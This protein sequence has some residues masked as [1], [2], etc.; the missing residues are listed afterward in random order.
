MVLRKS[1]SMED[2]MPTLGMLPNLRDLMLE[3]AYNGKKK[4][5]ID[6][7]FRQLEFL[8]LYHLSNL[9]RWHLA[10]SAMPLIKSLAISRCSKL[11]E[12]PERMKYVEEKLNAVDL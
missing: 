1:K 5:C 3:D 10:T 6:S 4:M 9:E 12:I 11:K 7:S 8:H 2:P